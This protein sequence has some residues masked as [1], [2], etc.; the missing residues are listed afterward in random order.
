MKGFSVEWRAMV[1]SFISRGSMAIKVNDDVGPYFQMKKGLRQGNSI[2][3]ML[4]NTVADMLA[5]MIEHAKA[6][7]QIDGLV[8]HL[9][10]GGL[11]IFQYAN[12]KIL[13]MDHDLE[14]GE[15]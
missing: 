10:D 8:N 7:G 2:S 5:A 13:F 15:I 11:A 14:K 4:F 1:H 3:P 12:D 9:V 6:D